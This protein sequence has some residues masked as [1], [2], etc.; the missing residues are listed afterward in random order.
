[1]T[2]PKRF[3]KGETRGAKIQQKWGSRKIREEGQ[4]QQ[5]KGSVFYWMPDRK[6]LE[7]FKQE[8][9]PSDFHWKW[10]TPAVAWRC[11]HNRAKGRG[12]ETNEHLLR[13][14]R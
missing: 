5:E 9:M 4:P 11:N 12:R 2:R 14:S 7:G 13:V 6:A 10:I 8:L 3:C 1:M